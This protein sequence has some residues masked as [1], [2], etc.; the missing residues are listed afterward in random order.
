[1]PPATITWTSPGFDSIGTVPPG[2]RPA[3]SSAASYLRR[4]LRS[5]LTMRYTPDLSFFPDDSIE[6]GARM[7]SLLNE[8][9]QQEPTP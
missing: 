6:N 8:L 1:M 5:H 7:L 3:L 4:E 2:C 9:K